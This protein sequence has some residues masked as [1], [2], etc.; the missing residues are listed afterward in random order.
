MLLPD[1]NLSA[2]VC[3]TDESAASPTVAQKLSPGSKHS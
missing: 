1:Q 2:T 3:Y